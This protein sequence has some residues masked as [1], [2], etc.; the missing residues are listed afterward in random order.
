MNG[1]PFG[2][3]DLVAAIMFGMLDEECDD[4]KVHLCAR[5]DSPI[6]DGVEECPVCAAEYEQEG[7]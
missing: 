1:T 7:F 5:C 3:D 4:P 6:E 2:G